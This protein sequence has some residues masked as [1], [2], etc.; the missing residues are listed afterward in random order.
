MIPDYQTF[1]R[2]QDKRIVMLLCAI[3]YL[4][5]GLYWKNTAFNLTSQDAIIISAILALVM[6]HFIWELKAYWAYK[7]VVKNIDLSFFVN[8][9]AS[10]TE[11]VLSRP[12]SASLLSG[13]LFWL[14]TQMALLFFTPERVLPLLAAVSPFFLYI[15]F[16]FIRT[17]YIKLLGQEVNEKL[18]FK[19]LH[20]YVARHLLISLSVTLLTIVPLKHQPEFS[21]DEGLFSARLIVAM[22]VLCAVVLAIN[23][24]FVR[25]SRRYIFLGRLFTREIDF[26]F[27]SPL[28]RC[29][30]VATPLWIQLSSLVLIET[31]WIAVISLL[32][33]LSGRA[34]FF[35]AYFLLCLLPCLAFSFLY[36]YR[37]WH[38]DFLMACDMC[39]RWEEINKQS[40]LW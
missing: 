9:K 13:I 17:T 16:R 31:L 10:Q 11:R 36:I 1:I 23:L 18:R 28:P 27:A 2:H 20:R 4:L 15:V 37:L 8:K 35:E 29:I 7:C 6:F 21:L 25:L 5:L 32:L 22:L 30:D 34:I 3:I 12:A 24:I 19:H 26:Y 38:N 33:G 40:Q 39:F 14:I